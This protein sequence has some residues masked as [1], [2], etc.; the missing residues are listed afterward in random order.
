MK[1]FLLDDRDGYGLW[2]ATHAF[3]LTPTALPNNTRFLKTTQQLFGL[4][5]QPP[6]VHV[7]DAG[8]FS[9]LSLNWKS[10][11]YSTEEDEL[12]F[13]PFPDAAYS[14]RMCLMRS[15]T[16]ILALAENESNLKNTRR[17]LLKIHPVQHPVLQ[18]N[19]LSRSHVSR[20]CS[21]QPPPPQYIRR[22]QG[23]WTWYGLCHTSKSG[24]LVRTTRQS[25]TLCFFRADLAGRI[26][27][28]LDPSKPS[29][30]MLQ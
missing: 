24:A 11:Y 22:K 10:R 30:R 23:T 19:A 3:H 14:F 12:D 7:K 8:T 28:Q 25:Y 15:A 2:Q 5:E 6:S 21:Q 1:Q 9:G 27:V 13:A 4:M 17:V 16:W 18:P 20:E 29:A 26:Q